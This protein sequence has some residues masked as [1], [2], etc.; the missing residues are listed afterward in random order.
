MNNKEKMLM[1][2]EKEIEVAF[3]PYKT[4]YEILEKEPPKSVEQI[5]SEIEWGVT[6][7]MVEITSE[8]FNTVVGSFRDFI[9]KV[10]LSFMPEEF[11]E[12]AAEYF[13]EIEQEPVVGTLQ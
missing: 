11:R 7:E 13:K 10:A 3:M 1:I 6:D 8:Y 5:M 4:M 12:E 2:F 9:K